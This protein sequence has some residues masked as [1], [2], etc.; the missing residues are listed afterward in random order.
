VDAL[1][2][3]WRYAETGPTGG[4]GSVSTNH[5]V[6]L[7]TGLKP[8]AVSAWQNDAHACAYMVSG[9]VEPGVI[10]G[11]IQDGTF[12]QFF[13]IAASYTGVGQSSVFWT[14]TGYPTSA[15]T[16][17][18]GFYLASRTSGGATG[19]T[20]YHS[21]VATGSSSSVGGD[22]ASITRNI[23]ILGTN[24]GDT[25]VINMSTNSNGG[26]AIGR[27]I[28]AS[29]ATNAYYQ[30]WQQYETLLGRQK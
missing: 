11:A 19:V 30:A 17:G 1:Q 15:D 29:V 22:P 26:Y 6:G 28:T 14:P 25:T 3:Y 4:L 23:Y 20:Q 24:V 9:K 7:D 13:Q 18:T 10:M 16:N 2:G 27:G 21:G 12:V 8:S 5:Y